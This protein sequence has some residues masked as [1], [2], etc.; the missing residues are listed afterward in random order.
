MNIKHICGLD[1]CELISICCSVFPLMNIKETE[2]CSACY[3]YTGFE[4]MEAMDG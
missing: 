4:C 3:E 1:D 2:I